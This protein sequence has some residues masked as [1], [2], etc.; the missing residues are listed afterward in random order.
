MHA[1]E[2]RRRYLSCTELS[3][4]SLPA[5]LCDLP[6]GLG[7]ECGE[8]EPVVIL[9]FLEISKGDEKELIEF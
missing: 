4:G 3:L 2:R 1:G 7:N 9:V 8:R 6:G 5:V